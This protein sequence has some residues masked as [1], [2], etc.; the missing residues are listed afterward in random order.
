MSPRFTR[1]RL[2]LTGALMAAAAAAMPPGRRVGA[3]APETP[4]AVVL[5]P[6]AAAAPGFEVVLVGCK[7]TLAAAATPTAFAAAMAGWLA[8]VPRQ[9]IR[10]RLIVFPEDVGLI[11]AFTGWRGAP[12]RRLRSITGAMGSLLL[13][14]GPEILAWRR[15]FPQVALPPGDLR[16]LWLA[17]ADTMLQA[18]MGAFQPLARAYHAYLVA[19]MPAPLFR[20]SAGADGS[21]PRYRPTAPDIYNTAFVFGPDGRLIDRVHKVHLVPTEQTLLHLSPGRLADVHALRLPGVGR[22]GVVISKDAW[23]PDVVE[24]L[25]QDGARILVQPD[26]NDAPWANRPVLTDWQP[27]RWKAGNW[28]SVQRSPVIRYSLNP[29]LTGNLFTLPFDGQTAVIGKAADFPAPRGYI[30]QRPDSGYAAVAPW[31]LP[32]PTHLPLRRRRCWLSRQAQGLGPL[33]GSPFRDAY[34]AAVVHGSLPLPADGSLPSSGDPGP[35][36]TLSWT[37]SPRAIG[38]RWLPT[39]AATGECVYW[40]WAEA[41]GDFAAIRAAVS[42]DG[43]KSFTPL[44]LETGRRQAAPP[45]QWRP[46]GTVTAD[47]RACL[48]WL[49]AGANGWSVRLGLQSGPAR[50]TVLAPP[51]T[52]RGQALAT[53]PL[54]LGLADGSLLVAWSDNRLANAVSDI[55]L[56]GSRNGGQRFEAPVRVSDTPTRTVGRLGDGAP[57]VYGSGY[58]WEPALAAFGD[59]VV[60]AWQDFRP[61]QP[62]HPA[63]RRNRVRVAVSFDGGRHFLP[64][65]VVDDADSCEQYRPRLTARAGRAVLGWLELEAGL[66]AVGG[67]IS[68]W[69]APPSA[70]W[71]WQRLAAPAAGA[72]IQDFALAAGED[73]ALWLAW[74]DT[75]GRLAVA[76][77]G[78]GSWYTRALALPT[79]WRPL[80]PALCPLPRGAMFLTW[81]WVAPSGSSRVAGLG[82][83]PDLT[84]TGIVEPPS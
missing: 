57:V 8:A 9:A 71:V 26:A 6:L 48:A 80:A 4:T 59:T 41:T 15:R 49:E 61:R 32:D 54:P 18:F 65:A 76:R 21:P 38:E 73:G 64:S 5:P 67:A 83:L 84:L 69:Q 24:R 33:P 44:A 36:P 56:V 72:R 47:G 25:E 16:L 20:V 79:A 12:A 29:M 23:M 1:R 55:Y 43:G 2:L 27:D 17:L 34:N 58:A 66:A 19:C 62:G 7:Q 52:P 3:P 11:T 22:I 75:A 42:R 74:T 77:R 70:P 39:V 13:T 63:S 37:P 14:Y 28:V 60:V 35:L 10:P 68:L 51:V 46:A 53:A 81:Q 78:G 45:A 31:A 82:C 50:L 40:A 30:G